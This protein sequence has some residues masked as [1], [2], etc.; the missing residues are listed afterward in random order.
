MGF[1]LTSS[2]ASP[3]SACLALPKT[4]FPCSSLPPTVHKP[5]AKL[6]I[7]SSLCSQM[8]TQI[9]Q[10]ILSLMTQKKRRSS[11]TQRPSCLNLVLCLSGLF[12]AGGYCHCFPGTWMSRGR[13]GFTWA[14]P[15]GQPLGEPGR[16]YPCEEAA[17]ATQEL[18]SV[19]PRG[20]KVDSCLFPQVALFIAFK[21]CQ[22]ASVRT[23]RAQKGILGKHRSHGG[24][25]QL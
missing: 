5:G 3:S 12:L 1:H 21:R 22:A 17:T 13:E 7:T 20:S 11:W 23:E 6:A 9:F 4:I 24:S 18:P 15:P 19:C 10:D 16:V 25:A 2:P 8:R 14:L